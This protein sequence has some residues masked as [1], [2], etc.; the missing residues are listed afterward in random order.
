MYLSDK[1]EYIKEISGFNEIRQH[2]AIVIS[3]LI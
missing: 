1:M 2:A 3:K